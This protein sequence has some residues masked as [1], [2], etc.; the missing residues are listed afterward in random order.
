MS[1][2]DLLIGKTEQPGLGARSWKGRNGRAVLLHGLSSSGGSWWRIG[3]ALADRGWDVQAVDLPGHGVSPRLDPELA[4]DRVAAMVDSELPDGPIDLLAGHSFGALVALELAAGSPERV[5][6]LVLEEP[7]G[8]NSIDF[9]VAADELVRT[10]REARSDPAGKLAELRA[11]CPR[12]ADGDCRQAVADLIA[13]DSEYG[14]AGFRA[15]PAWRTVSLAQ[16]IRAPALVL[17][18]PDREG[19]YDEREDGTTLRGD[20]RTGF[21][22]ALGDARVRVL[23]TGHCVHRDDAAGWLDAVFDFVG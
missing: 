15:G 11:G 4:P 3:P 2:K 8:P 12:W 10:A 7:P 17:L 14:G 5:R 6:R 9:A 22:E 1:S 19:L 20:E 23:D 18:A 16:S 21:V 13:W